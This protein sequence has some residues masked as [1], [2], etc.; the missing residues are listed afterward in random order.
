MG[1][2]F[3]RVCLCVCLSALWKEN[4]LSYQQ[5]TWYTYTFCLNKICMYI[6]VTRHALTHGSKVQRWRLHGYEN[7][8]GRT[9]ASDMCCYGCVLLLLAWVCMSIWLRMFSCYCCGDVT[10]FLFE[11]AAA[12]LQGTV[13]TWCVPSFMRVKTSL[14]QRLWIRVFECGT[15][16]V[17][18]FLPLL[19]FAQ[20]IYSVEF[21][22]IHIWQKMFSCFTVGA[23]A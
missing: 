8:H 12:F 5:Q 13:I 15:F 23:V 4:D 7:H 3:R 10:H 6:A 9:V 2:A 11:L 16:L 1:I 14:C 19:D 21:V 20:V 22:T 17:I 18:W